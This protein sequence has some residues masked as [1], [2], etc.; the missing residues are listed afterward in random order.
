MGHQL[1]F[2]LLVVGGPVHFG[3]GHIVL[4]LAVFGVEFIPVLGL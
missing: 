1:G 3:L 2:A 4:V